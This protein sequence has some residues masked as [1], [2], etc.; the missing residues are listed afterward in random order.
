[1]PERHRVEVVCQNKA[2]REAFVIDAFEYFEDRHTKDWSW[3][4]MMSEK[5]GGGK[6]VPEYGIREWYEKHPAHQTVR[7]D[8]P[9]GVARI[10]L[11]CRGKGH[12]DI[13]MTWQKFIDEYLEPMR[14]GGGQQLRV[15]LIT[16]KETGR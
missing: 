10:R 6:V 16:K 8:F 12:A 13:G 3:H 4:W 9:D 2:H 7:D 14:A 15:S 11:R 5:L 1:M